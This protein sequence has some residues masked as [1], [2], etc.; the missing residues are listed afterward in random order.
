MPW[1]ILVVAVLVGAGS[2]ATF[3]FVRGLDYLPTLPFAIV[4]GAILFAVPAAVLGLVLTGAWSL[5]TALR[6]GSA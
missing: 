4:E 3:G 2:G 5:G 1:R 6:R